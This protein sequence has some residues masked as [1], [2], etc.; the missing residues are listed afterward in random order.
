MFPFL[1]LILAFIF[2]HYYSIVLLIIMTPAATV[3]AVQ[4]K[5]VPSPRKKGGQRST[6]NTAPPLR[7]QVATLLTLTVYAFHETIGIEAYIFAK[8]DAHDGFTNA[9]VTVFTQI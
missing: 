2:R 8:D 3:S 4:S 1:V 6:K 7:K 5:G 9:S